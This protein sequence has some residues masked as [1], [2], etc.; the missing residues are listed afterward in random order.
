MGDFTFWL[1][2]SLSHFAEWKYGLSTYLAKKWSDFAEP[3]AKPKVWSKYRLSQ[4]QVRKYGLST[5]LDQSLAELTWL[6]SVKFAWK[7]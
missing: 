2:L 3:F 4:S 1:R 7:R 5:Y 6:K